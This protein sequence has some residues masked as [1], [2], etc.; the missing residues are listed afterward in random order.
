MQR[1]PSPLPDAAHFVLRDA[2]VPGCLLTANAGTADG[3]GLVRV[4]IEIADGRVIGI[5]GPVEL[6]ATSP[7][8]IDLGGCQ[9]WPCFVDLHTHLDKGHIWPRAAN[10]DGTFGGALAASAADR[11]ARWSERDVEA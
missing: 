7:P 11:G 4:D 9:V 2:A 5:G 1:W 8:A 3:D 6:D 10:A